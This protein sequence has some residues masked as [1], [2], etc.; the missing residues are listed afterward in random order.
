[1]RGLRVL[2]AIADAGEIRADELAAEVGLPQSTTYRYLKTLAAMNLIEE[3][4]S[5]YLL[6]WRMLEMSGQHLVHTRLVEV[7]QPFLRNLTEATGET[8]VLAVRVGLQAMCLRQVESPE[9]LR[10]AFRINQLLP[11][12]AAAG[13]RMLLAHAPPAVIERLLAGPLRHHTSTTPDREVLRRELDQLRRTGFAVSHGEYVPGAVA[14]A[15]PVSAGGEVVATLTVAGPQERCTASWIGM[16]RR[17]LAQSAEEFAGALG[18]PTVGG[19]SQG[20]VADG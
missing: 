2:M 20:V 17:V 19:R 1:M 6:G 14:V 11:L 5:S 16:A 4:D 15:V 13:Q 12:Y 3:R 18:E 8:A 9:P 7:G 10:I